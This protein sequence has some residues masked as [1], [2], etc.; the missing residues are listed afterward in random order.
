MQNQYD[1][2]VARIKRL[3]GIYFEGPRKVLWELYKTILLMD[4]EDLDKTAL[5]IMAEGHK[6]DWD[7]PLIN[8]DDPSPSA[9][10]T[11]APGLLDPISLPTD[12]IEFYERYC[13]LEE[14]KSFIESTDGHLFKDLVLTHPLAKTYTFPS[15]DK[16]DKYIDLINW[17]FD[18]GTP[19]PA[20]Y[21]D[22]STCKSNLEMYSNVVAPLYE[23]IFD[24]LW[25][26]MDVNTTAEAES[27]LRTVQNLTVTLYPIL[28]DDLRESDSSDFAYTQC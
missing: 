7:I 15:L 9:S 28:I 17:L 1:D 19:D 18:G 8:P 11:P 2:I 20:T 21:P 13:I 25:A 10:P 3:G 12:E 6:Y 26:V 23:Q 16:A 4:N 27:Y 5:E 14:L 24:P 22:H